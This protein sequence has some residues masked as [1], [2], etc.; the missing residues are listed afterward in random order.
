MRVAE[1]ASND[2][3]GG[4]RWG[5]TPVARQKATQYALYG[6]LVLAAVAFV[7]G[8]DFRAIQQS[9]LNPDIARNMFPEVLTQ[10]AVNT[11]LYTFTS[12]IFGLVFGLLLA[13]MR[14]SAIAP[15]RWMARTYIEFFRALPALVT[16]LLIGF[17]V[18]IAF[19]VNIPGGTLGK[20]TLGLG[21]VAAAY[22]AETIRAGIEAVPKGQV[23]AA[24]SLGMSGF[25]TLISIVIP[26]AFRIIIPP[27]TNELVL[28]IK[29]TS[30]LFV[31]GTTPAS[32]ELLKFG[33]DLQNTTFNGTPLIV[34]AIVYVAITLPLTL[35]VA[36]LEKRNKASK[37]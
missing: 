15:Y 28:L 30:L 33:R 12:F 21:I 3:S 5:M 24:R 26:Q 1:R 37:A 17:A 36:Q 29:D 35:L 8:A 31:L 32:K 23:E 14:L 2:L 34:V 27:L 25:W 22:M 19:D 9:F 11:L 16:I 10:A 18:P 4:A 13:L 7:V 6:L 20:A